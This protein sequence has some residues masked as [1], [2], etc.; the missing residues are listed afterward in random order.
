MREL[1]EK[2]R[3]NN[4]GEEKIKTCVHRTN[5]RIYEEKNFQKAEERVSCWPRAPKPENG[6]SR[7]T[8]NWHERSKKR[9]KDIGEN[10]QGDKS[11]KGS[12]V[13]GKNKIQLGFEIC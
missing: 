9:G 2:E 8:D 13:K 6:P 5:K 4:R 3:G 12:W 7:S 11:G 10:F 1:G